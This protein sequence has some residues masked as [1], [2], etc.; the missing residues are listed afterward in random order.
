MV[1]CS[2][3]VITHISY[4][5]GRAKP[6]LGDATSLSSNSAWGSLRPAAPEVILPKALRYKSRCPL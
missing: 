4:I 3:V 1:E 5:I 2:N 6:F